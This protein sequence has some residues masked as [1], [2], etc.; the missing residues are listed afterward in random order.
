MVM[1]KQEIKILFN[2]LK[3]PLWAFFILGTLVFGFSL[4]RYDFGFIEGVLV[5]AHGMLM[6]IVVFA[7]LFVVSNHFLDKQRR[8]QAILDELSDFRFWKSELARKKNAGNIKRLKTLGRKQVDLYSCD[9][10]ME[11]LKE[12]EFIDS[13][14]NCATFSRCHLSECTF[15]NV[16]FRGASFA[17]STIVNCRFL[18]CNLDGANFFDANLLNNDFKGTRL[19]GNQ[20]DNLIKANV[21]YGNQNV[22]ED[23]IKNIEDTH[24]ELLYKPTA[25]KVNRFHKDKSLSDYGPLHD[26]VE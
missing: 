16:N 3:T 18:N 7:G 26:D 17:K 15:R 22:S 9:F 20:S 13:D 23:V 11:H 24:P 4:K 19:A 10:E 8:I 25:A 1:S 21:F 6:D 2:E 14:F 5:E 12:F